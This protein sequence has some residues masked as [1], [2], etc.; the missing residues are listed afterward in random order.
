MV[1]IALFMSNRRWIRNP[2]NLIFVAASRLTQASL[3]REWLLAEQCSAA[4]VHR[5]LRKKY[6]K[7]APIQSER[8]EQEQGIESEIPMAQGNLSRQHG[9]LLE[10]RGNR[11]SFATS[12]IRFKNLRRGAHQPQHSREPRRENDLCSQRVRLQDAREG[13]K[14]QTEFGLQ[15]AL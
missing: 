2:L 5:W 12:T 9:S 4:L 3:W 7:W 6:P 11:E 1:L 15:P 14:L 10:R 8:R 13:K